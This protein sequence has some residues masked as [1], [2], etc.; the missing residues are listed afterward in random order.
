M[1]QNDGHS[2]N[3]LG[4]FI[5]DSYLILHNRPRILLINGI[6]QTHNKEASTRRVE[7][8]FLRIF[9]VSL[10][11]QVLRFAGMLR[12]KCLRNKICL[13]QKLHWQ[14]LLNLV[15]YC[16]DPIAYKGY[17]LLILER[18]FKPKRTWAY[19]PRYFSSFYR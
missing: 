18:R 12:V 19:W 4:L 15:Q 2:H 8:F 5:D 14:Y 17:L 3:K 6:S 11:W 1:N 16:S 9:N 7:T 10:L 13:P